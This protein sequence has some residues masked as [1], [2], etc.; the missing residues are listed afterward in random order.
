MRARGRGRTAG[1]VRWRRW[2]AAVIT[3]AGI[4][5]LSGCTAGDGSPDDPGPAGTSSRPA[6]QATP[7]ATVSPSGN[8]R[9][10]PVAPTASATPLPALGTHSNKQWTLALTAVR[11]AGPDAIVV[12]GVLTPVERSVFTEFTEQGFEYR[13]RT[14]PA[15]SGTIATREFSAVRLSV[16][17]D[18]TAYLPMRDPE[19]ACACTEV[20]SSGIAP[21]QGQG[22]YVYMTA[23]PP[24]AAAV[25][26]F[27]KGFPTFRDVPVSP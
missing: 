14:A 15:G 20:Y 13:R 11:R 16:R 17:G 6:G 18:K 9:P 5:V 2:Q 25:D 4:A 22:V 12:E 8:A 1:T 26:V 3:V 10:Y 7:S 19:G 27:V 21:D 23:P 24:D